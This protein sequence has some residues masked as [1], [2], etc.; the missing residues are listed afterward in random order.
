MYLI[1][2]LQKTILPELHIGLLPDSPSHKK[3]V[4]VEFYCKVEVA[5]PGLGMSKSKDKSKLLEQVSQ[6]PQVSII[7][8]LALHPQVTLWPCR[9]SHLGS[10]QKRSKIKVV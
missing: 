6:S 9:K 1:M 7:M 8:A 4:L 5:H 2:G 10:S 3:M